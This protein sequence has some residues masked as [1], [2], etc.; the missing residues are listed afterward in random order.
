[1]IGLAVVFAVGRGAGP[2]TG[3]VDRWP[4][5]EPGDCS[6]FAGDSRVGV[7]PRVNAAPGRSEQEEDRENNQEDEA[8]QDLKH[9]YRSLQSKL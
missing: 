6:D 4:K 9:V 7:V 1:M 3:R 8:E 2:G 5:V